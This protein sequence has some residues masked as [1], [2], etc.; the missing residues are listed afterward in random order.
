MNSVDFSSQKN[1]L[2]LRQSDLENQINDAKQ[3]NK[4]ALLS[5]LELK[6]VHRYGIAEIEK[7]RNINDEQ[8]VGPLNNKDHQKLIDFTEKNAM[9]L[10]SKSVNEVEEQKNNHHVKFVPENI[11]SNTY[12]DQLIKEDIIKNQSATPP[13]QP[14]LNHLRKWLTRVDDDFPKAS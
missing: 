3:H 1:S 6:L 9:K 10:D 13:P 8:G 4:E 2:S 12:T 5:L 11:T 7:S 14:T